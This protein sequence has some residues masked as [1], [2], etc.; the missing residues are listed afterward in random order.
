[1]SQATPQA[2]GSCGVE[3]VFLEHVR[4]L[5]VAPIELS[6][7]PGGNIGIDLLAGTYM[8]LNKVQLEDARR[9]GKK[10]HLNH[11]ASCPQAGSWHRTPAARKA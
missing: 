6:S 9:A 1:V 8:V 10:L 7:D 5:R 4:T 2:C 3:V 11:F